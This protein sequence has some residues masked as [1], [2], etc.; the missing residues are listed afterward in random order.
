MGYANINAGRMNKCGKL[1]RA[2]TISGLACSVQSDCSASARTANDSA[3]SPR[4]FIASRGAPR[5]EQ[6]H[7]LRPPAPDR[8]VQRWIRIRAAPADARMEVKAEVQ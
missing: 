6:L 1:R 5:H 7:S 2:A 8:H 3:V 4:P